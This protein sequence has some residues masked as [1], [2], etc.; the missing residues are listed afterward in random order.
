MAQVVEEV[1][2]ALSPFAPAGSLDDVFAMDA[3]ARAAAEECG[4]EF[5]VKS[6]ANPLYV[7]PGSPYVRE[8]L[9]LADR[10]TPTTGS[11]GTDGAMFTALKKLIV[12]GPGDIAQADTHDEWISLEQLERGSEMFD[13]RFKKWCI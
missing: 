8:M 1:L 11:Y 6:S 13:R 12:F 10:Q 9:D 3:R 4:L 2:S 5:E 7:D